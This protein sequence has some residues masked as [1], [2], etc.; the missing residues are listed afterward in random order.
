MY[1]TVLIKIIIYAY[2]KFGLETVVQEN[3]NIVTSNIGVFVDMYTC[4]ME[5]NACVLENV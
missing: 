4:F 3:K 2:S 5:I 1:A